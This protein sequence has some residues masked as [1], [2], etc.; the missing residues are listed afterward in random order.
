MLHHY[1]SVSLACSIFSTDL[2]YGHY[3]TQRHGII[4]PVVWLTTS[5]NEKEHGLLTGQKINNDK[6]RAYLA[7]VQGKHAKNDFTH[8]KTKIRIDI[9]ENNLDKFDPQ[10]FGAAPQSQWKGLVDYE[11]FS[12]L[13]L[14]EDKLFRNA[15]GLSCFHDLSKLSD[16][17]AKALLHKKQKNISTWKLYFG[18]IHPNHFTRVR[19][20]QNNG[21]YVPFDFEQHGRDECA[22]NGIHYLPRDV[23]KEYAALIHPLNKYEVP[24]LAAFCAEPS[25]EAHIKCQSGCDEWIIK[26]DDSLAC[27]AVR[28]K[29]P[30][31]IEL[32]RELVADNKE[33]AMTA[34]KS[35]VSSYFDFYP[36]SPKI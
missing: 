15:I 31:N 9:E 16:H 25:E 11:K 18:G 32:I 21:E 1:T 20:K 2:R 13:V 4:Q 24:Y 14:G 6:D 36:A 29:L 26:L 28:G 22:N 27:E 17:E 12:R 30:E 8:D 10:K 34:W 7:K 19:F 5:L 3:N 33:K 23:L 35:A